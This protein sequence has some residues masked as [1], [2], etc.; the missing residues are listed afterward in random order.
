MIMIVI[1][2]SIIILVIIVII[3]SIIC[4]SSSSAI[5]IIIIVIIAISRSITEARAALGADRRRGATG[6][7][8]APGWEEGRDL[9][10]LLVYS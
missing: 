8:E 10:Q 2:I 6:A 4:A 7:A 1:I 5:V 3:I 9:V